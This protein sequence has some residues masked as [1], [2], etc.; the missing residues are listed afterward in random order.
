[1]SE[2]ELAYGEAVREAIAQEMRR[3]EDVAEEDR[4]HSVRPPQLS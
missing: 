2:C 4:R 3:E 1:M